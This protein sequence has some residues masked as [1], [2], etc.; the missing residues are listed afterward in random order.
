MGMVVKLAMIAG[1][2][3]A[4]LAAPVFADWPATLE[5]G[6]FTVSDVRG[7]TNPDG[8]GRATGRL[9]LPGRGSCRVD[10]ACTA[11]GVVT[12][13]TR[14]SFLLGG[15]RIDGSFLL[16]RRGMQGTGAVQ[17]RG[18]PISDANLTVNPRNVMGRG[19]VR[20]SSD[21]SI[22]V[23]FEVSQQ[24]VSV[25]GSAPRQAS[26]DTPLAVYTLRG[27]VNISASG[28]S[29]K[30]TA[31]GNVERQGKIGGMVSTFGPLSFDVDPASGEARLSV[32][33]AN[34]TFDLW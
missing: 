1:V 29:L 15:V 13:S 34:I 32:G 25:R 18:R 33:G 28:A 22:V 21:L 7:T 6:G 9:S 14:S 8:S 10:L 16:D 4:A 12:G 11:S 17:T 20:L 5:I 26:V 24:G 30:A 31:E 27:V 23:T 19:R 3:A 2:V